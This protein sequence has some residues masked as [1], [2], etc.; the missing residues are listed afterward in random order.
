MARRL[1]Q[2]DLDLRDAFKKA[3]Q[4][5]KTAVVSSTNR[6]KG[7]TV[8]GRAVAFQV[9]PTG[10]R[11]I[12]VAPQHT[13]IGSSTYADEYFKSGSKGTYKNSHMPVSERTEGGSIVNS[14]SLA[15]R[16]RAERAG[17]GAKPSAGASKSTSS[18]KVKPVTSGMKIVAKLMHGKATSGRR[19]R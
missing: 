5:A 1:T 17:G 19:G 10:N 9:S 4:Q 6:V 14:R 18:A 2:Y 13:Q 7:A 15:E 11:F 8:N 16:A 3:D 12:W